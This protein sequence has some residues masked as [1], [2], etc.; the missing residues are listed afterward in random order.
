MDP[1]TGAA[2]SGVMGLGGAMLS[3]QQSRRAQKREH[4]FVERMSSTAHQREV[5]DLRAAGLNPILSAGGGGASTPGASG[6]AVPDY[7]EKAQEA[8]S[9]AL[10][11]KEIQQ[12]ASL[13]HQQKNAIAAQGVKDTAAAD[14]LIQ[15]M[16]T[17]VANTRRVKAEAEMREVVAK[18]MKDNPNMTQWLKTLS[19]LLAPASSVAGASIR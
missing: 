8:V 5:K 12:K 10:Q 2:L 18:H 16:Q 19:P 7:G 15:Q 3:G 4:A 13:M 6:M 9:T 14:L 11:A 1:G 17:E